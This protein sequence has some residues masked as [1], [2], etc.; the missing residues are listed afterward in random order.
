MVKSLP[1]NAGDSRD[2]G[3]IPGSGRSPEEGMATHSS[4][5]AWKILWTEEPRG[6]SPWGHKELGYDGVHSVSLIINIQRAQYKKTM[7]KDGNVT[8]EIEILRK[9]QE[10]MLQINNAV[11]EMKNVFDGFNNDNPVQYSCL[12]NPMGRGAWWAA[13]HGVAKSRT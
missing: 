8:V 4:I 12:E 9:T 5:L 11:V 3:L 2:M 1:A 6:Y 7:R 10:D 13:V